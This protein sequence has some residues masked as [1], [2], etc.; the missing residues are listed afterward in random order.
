MTQEEIL[1]GLKYNLKISG[2][3]HDE[4]LKQKI[5]ETISY[6]ELK[7]GVKEAETISKYAYIVIRGASDLFNY[8]NYQ[9]L[10]LDLIKNI[11][12]YGSG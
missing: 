5:A 1:Q 3:Y 8:D 4:D 10:F 6:I 12:I 9:E 2:Y 11:G 7:T